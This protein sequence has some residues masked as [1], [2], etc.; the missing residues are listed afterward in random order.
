[1]TRY[2]PEFF[3]AQAKELKLRQGGNM[4]DRAEYLAEKICS[5]GDYGDEA[6][7]LLR[8]Q[9]KEIIRLRQGL[10]YAYR[11]RILAFGHQRRDTQMRYSA[12]FLH[13][14]NFV[15]AAFFLIY[16]DAQEYCDIRLAE[17]VPD[18][19]GLPIVWRVRPL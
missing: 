18:E 4:S 19:N 3:R 12:E 5:F 13:R 6:A 1:M 9:A 8:T 16:P 7:Q 2:T 10:A 15:A 17:K 14:G 11:K